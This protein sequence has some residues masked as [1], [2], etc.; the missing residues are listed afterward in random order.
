MTVATDK[1]GFPGLPPTEDRLLDLAN[2]LTDLRWR[3]MQDFASMLWR[4]EKISQFG[5][6]GSILDWAELYKTR[7][8]GDDQ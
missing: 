8:K 1:N 5:I 2:L 3:E 6:A 7:V 4:A